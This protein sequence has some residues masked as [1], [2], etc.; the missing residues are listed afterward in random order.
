MASVNIIAINPS[1]DKL[2]KYGWQ[3]ADGA[4]E[5]KYT[6]VIDRNGRRI[7]T[8]RARFLVQIM[9]LEDKPVIPLDFWVHNEYELNKNGDKCK[10]IDSYVRTAWATKDDIKAKRVPQYSNGPAAISQQYTLCHIGEE[11]ILK[12]IFKYLNITPFRVFDKV[13]NQF[14]PSKNP[15]R[16]TIDKWAELTGRYKLLAASHN[17]WVMPL[18]F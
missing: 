3:I 5:P 17:Q 1:N 11:A 8:A 2:R 9:D 15:G 14:V 16:L 10:I 12:F 6:A 13:T 4:D 18:K 7:E